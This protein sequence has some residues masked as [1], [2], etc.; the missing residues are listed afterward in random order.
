[1]SNMSNMSNISNTENIKIIRRI[2]DINEDCWCRLIEENLNAAKKLGF[3]LFFETFKEYVENSA[4]SEDDILNICLKV[5]EAIWDDCPN[6]K[7]SE[8]KFDLEEEKSE[9]KSSLEQ[10]GFKNPNDHNIEILKVYEN[11]EQKEYVGVIIFKNNIFPMKWDSEGKSL[12]DDWDFNLEPIEYKQ[13]LYTKPNNEGF[14]PKQKFKVSW[15]RDMSSSLESTGWRLA[16]NEEI[17]KFKI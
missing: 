11:Y 7:G 10:F 13:R 12:T 17:E 14:L 9:P 2:E 3:G 6:A 15:T 1:M 16:T 8:I 5:N 4:F